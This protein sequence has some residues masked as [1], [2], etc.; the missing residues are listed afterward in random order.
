MLNLNYDSAYDILN[1]SL[2]DNH[3]SIGCEEYGGLVVMRDYDTREITGLMLYGFIDK[4][5][6]QSIPN[7]PNE[8]D[9][10]IEKDI[11]PAF[12]LKY[13]CLLT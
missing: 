6:N 4:Y 2:C 11:L 9:I 8:I 13:S 5:K 12:P 7:F 3:N 10:T 1:I